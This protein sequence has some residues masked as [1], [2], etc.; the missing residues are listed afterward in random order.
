MEKRERI[1]NRKKC[2]QGDE[3]E[4]IDLRTWREF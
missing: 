3:M 4:R 2:Q 1:G